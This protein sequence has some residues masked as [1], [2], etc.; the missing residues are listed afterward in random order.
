MGD[1]RE[2]KDADFQKSFPVED[3][4]DTQSTATIKKSAAYNRM[5]IVGCRTD[6]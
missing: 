6:N 1:E 3:K 5:V 2:N 4:T